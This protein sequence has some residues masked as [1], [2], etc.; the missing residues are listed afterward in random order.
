MPV[1]D[2]DMFA[3]FPDLPARVGCNRGASGIDG[4]L[5]SGFGY[6]AG[7]QHPLVVVVGDL[8]FIHDINALTMLRELGQPVTIVV[9][10]NH[11][12]GIFSFLPIV[13]H[14]H[15]FEKAF[16]TPHQL[17]FRAIAAMFDLDYA[18]PEK[19]DAFLTVFKNAVNSGKNALIEINTDRQKNRDLHHGLLKE[20][21]TGL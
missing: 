1:R 3:D 4:N 9:I 18:S 5:A 20:L 14:E 17:N 19:N 8:T 2:F 21:N 6:A 11:G 10:N 15:I 13:K 7:N 16:A 12:G